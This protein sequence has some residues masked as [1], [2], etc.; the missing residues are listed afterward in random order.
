MTPPRGTCRRG[1]RRRQRRR[2]RPRPTPGTHPA[3]PGVEPPAASALFPAAA[4]KPAAE[5][6][7]APAV[8]ALQ[9]LGCYLV[10]EVPPD[11]VLI[12]DQ[13]ALHERALYER[14]LARLTA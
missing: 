6:P 12:V 10:V 14:L 13:H 5:P 8:R 11:E 4:A 3:T 9:V 2:S 1:R 7:P